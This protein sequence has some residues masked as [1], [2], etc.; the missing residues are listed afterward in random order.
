ML[1][2]T[3]IT[4]GRF[5]H[6]HLARQLQKHDLLNEIWTGYPKFKLKDEKGIPFSKIKTYPWFQAP[7][8]VKGKVGLG[9]WEYLDRQL[10]WLAHETLDKHVSKKIT[11][12]THLIALSGMGL[13]SGKKVQ[14][15]GG[16]YICD[17]GSS[18]IRYQDSILKEEYQ[19]YG[20]KF[21]GID[22][23]II[24]KE[25]E[26]YYTADYI[27]VPSEFVKQ[28]FLQHG[29][30]NEKI[31]KIPY[32]ANL[33]RFKKVAEIDKQKFRVLF[34]GNLSIQKGIFDLLRAFQLLKHPN[35]ELIIVGA[36]SQEIKNIIS[37]E[38]TDNVVF[39]GVVKNIELPLLYSTSN[40]FVLPSVQEGLAMVQGEAMAC[41]CPVIA[42][43][44]TGGA[45]LFTN[46]KEGFIVPIRNPIA[47]AE[48]LQLLADNPLKR[49]EMSFA[50]IGRIK[51]IGGWD[52]YGNEMNKFIASL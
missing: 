28:S 38:K 36:V 25:E 48:K 37:K 31:I 17:R 12:P 35:K 21:K 34:V 20:L 44:N 39:R 22:P 7:Y 49:K 19:R 11:D 26:E 51:S 2:V 40:V 16:K 8:M 47:I 23:R 29:I 15:L 27:T 1:K 52:D 33:D 3:Q 42:T 18:H 50:A 32:G 43:E 13:Y 30:K 41:G 9:D 45:D 5:H 46:E 10:A 4:I 6:F 14:K 24:E